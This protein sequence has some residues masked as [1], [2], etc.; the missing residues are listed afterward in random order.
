MT[1]H[2]AT[3]LTAQGFLEQPAVRRL[4][5]HCRWA[6]PAWDVLPVALLFPVLWQKFWQL[7]NL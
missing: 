7:A 2:D 3:E 4:C 1:R 5:K 6:R